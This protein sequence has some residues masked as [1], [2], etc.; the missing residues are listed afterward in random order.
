MSSARCMRNTEPKQVGSEM[1]RKVAVQTR[2]SKTELNTSQKSSD[3]SFLFYTGK[4]S[5][6]ANNVANKRK[7]NLKSDACF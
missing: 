4:Q 6:S 3:C 1:V 2:E 7:E 5:D